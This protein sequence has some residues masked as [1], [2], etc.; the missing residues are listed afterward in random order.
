MLIS[1]LS[2]LQHLMHQLGPVIAEISA[3]FQHETDQWEIEFEEQVALHLGWHAESSGL[4]LS[5]SLGPAQQERYADY[6]RAN[7]LWF[8]VAPLRIALRDPDEEVMLIGEYAAE[9]LSIEF[10]QQ[11]IHTFLTHASSIAQ[12]PDERD[13][14]DTPES[15]VETTALQMI[16]A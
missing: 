9:N 4:L 16:K 6:L 5:C 11:T 2:D 10:L 14:I 8:G 3:I 15:G 1:T 13:F 7:L 12:E